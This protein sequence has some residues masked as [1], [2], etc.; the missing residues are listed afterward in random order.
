MGPYNRLGL[1]FIVINEAELN[2]LIYFNEQQIFW[3]NYP[4]KRN[5]L[6]LFKI[7]VSSR[8]IGGLQISY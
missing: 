3:K 5:S 2:V 1:Y 6:E 4:Y 7:G 8:R